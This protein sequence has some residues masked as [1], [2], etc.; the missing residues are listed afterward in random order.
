MVELARGMQDANNFVKDLMKKISECKNMDESS[1]LELYKS[2]F[3]RKLEDIVTQLSTTSMNAL[4]SLCYELLKLEAD[5]KPE[6]KF[7]K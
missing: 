6:N 2:R 5:C 4:F 7:V 1:E 3:T